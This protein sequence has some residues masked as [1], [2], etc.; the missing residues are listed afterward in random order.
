VRSLKSLG[1]SR[2]QPCGPSRKANRRWDCRTSWTTSTRSWRGAWMAAPN[3]QSA[4]Q[5]QPSW[6]PTHARALLTP[7]L[8]VPLMISSQLPE[9]SAWL[10]SVSTTLSVA[11]RLD[12]LWRGWLKKTWQPSPPLTGRRFWPGRGPDRPFFRPIPWRLRHP[13]QARRPSL[14]INLRAQPHLS[15][16][17]RRRR[18]PK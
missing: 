15:T 7:D 2:T 11:V 16:S 13:L 17:G 8:N 1:P 6:S 10:L 9:I 12:I 3:P 4:V 18:N 14:L 5:L